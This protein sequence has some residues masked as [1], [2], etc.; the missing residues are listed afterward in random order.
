MLKQKLQ[1]DQ[2]TALKSGEKEKLSVLRYILAQ[3]KNK[4]IETRQE[5]TEEEVVAILRKQLK[6]LN[7]SVEAFEKGGR[8]DLVAEYKGQIDIL[9]PYLP[10]EISDEVLK[11]EIDALIAANKEQYEK[12]PKIIIGICMGALKAKANPQRIMAILNALQ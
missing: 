5:P 9:T 2:L 12:N 3:I 4:E 7:E 6:E 1:A 11:A 10:E 8:A